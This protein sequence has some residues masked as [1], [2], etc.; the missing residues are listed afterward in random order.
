[1]GPAKGFARAGDF[2]GA[3][4]G[5]VGRRGP[6]LGR[7]PEADG[8]PTRDQRRRRGGFGRRDRGIDGGLVVPVDLGD[9]PAIGGEAGEGVVRYRQRG[10]P[11]DGNAVVIEQHDELGEAQVAGERRRL[12]RDAL[13]Q[14]AVADD[15]VG[16]VIDDF[17][18]VAGLKHPLGQRHADGVGEP[19][20]QRSRRRLDAPGGAVF[21]VAGGTALEL[22]EAF[23]LADRHVLVAE[24]IEQGV[25]QH[26]AVPGREDEAVP[27]GPAGVGGVEFQMPGEED[28]GGIG[29]AHRH[30]GMA[31]LGLLHGVHGER[32][33]GVGHLP[34][35]GAR[36]RRIA[37]FPSFVRHTAHGCDRPPRHRFGV[38]S[39]RGLISNRAPIG[40][41]QSAEFG[42]RRRAFRAWG[43]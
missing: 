36:R 9:V 35:T 12:V 31:R 40:N 34:V 5:A 30:A 6:G 21:G 13:H 24:Q 19:L 43:R 4:G 11:V 32:P 39:D 42:P 3:Q 38:A 26:R 15:H 27:I 8:R 41:E 10:R 2:F 22:A 33:D 16:G 25:E 7:R 28:G 29:H 23:D 20:A 17:G 18:A 37:S 14:T 1:M